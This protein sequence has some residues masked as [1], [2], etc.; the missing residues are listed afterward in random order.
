MIFLAQQCRQIAG[1]LPSTPGEWEFG[2]LLMTEGSTRSEES[3]IAAETTGTMEA[4]E[5]E[6]EME[7]RSRGG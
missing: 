2:L 5:R 6:E 7:M 4:G 3:G 1:M